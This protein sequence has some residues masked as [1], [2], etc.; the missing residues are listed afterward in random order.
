MRNTSKRILGVFIFILSLSVIHWS[1]NSRFLDI[2]VAQAKIS[3][4][5]SDI[6]KEAIS[7]DKNNPGIEKAME[8]Q[9]RHT[10]R[11]MAKS[12][13]VGTATGLTDDGRPAILVFTKKILKAGE[14]P[15]SLE[16]VPVVVEVTGE[17]M[18]MKKD[19]PPQSAGTKID[20][21]AWWPRPVPI[22]VSTGNAGECSAG[23]IGARVKSGSTVYAL[24]NNHVY[25]LENGAHIGSEV[26]QPGLYDTGCQCDSANVIGTLSGYI[27][28]QFNNTSCPMNSSACNTVD[29]AIARTTTGNLDNATPKNGYGTP[30]TTTLRLANL[31]IGRAVQK[32]GRTTSLTTGTIIGI[33]ATITVSYGASGNAVFTNQIVVGSSHPFI[34]AGDSG[35]LLVTDDGNAYPVGLLF[36]GNSSGK[37]AFANP[38]NDVLSDLGVVVDGK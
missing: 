12:D 15:Q 19:G 2:G 6:G 28:I 9:N 11:L 8:V 34:K 26:L 21:T 1:G 5:M 3:Q 24:S 23:T 35:S 18:T 7:P 16:G 13:V 30:S 27:T 20:P 14:I 33:G 31:S 25:A 17:I 37:Y 22:G 32:Y 4:E 29:A 36:A 38:I 10:A